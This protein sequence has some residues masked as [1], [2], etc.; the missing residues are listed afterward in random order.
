MQIGNYTV[1]LDQEIGRGGFGNVFRATKSERQ[2]V[3]AKR[4]NLRMHERAH[5]Q[6]AI[7]FYNRP[8]EHMNLIQL[9]D[10]NRNRDEGRDI[11]EFWV[12]MQYAE[13]GDLNQYFR[14]YFPLVQNIKQKLILMKQIARGIAYLH[15]QDIVH[16]DIKPA[17]I[18]VSGSHIPV[19][20]VIK[21]T[22]LGLAKF[23]DRNATSSGMS[24]IAG[25]EKFRAPEFWK[26]G[27]DG[28]I[29]YHRH[30]DTFSAGLTFLSMLQATEGTQLIPALESTL[31]PANDGRMPIG[32]EMVSRE[33]ANQ[34]SITLAAEEHH[35][36]SL[37]RGVK[38][39]I[40]NMLHMTPEDRILM[41]EVDTLFADE[42]NLIRKVFLLVS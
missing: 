9:F 18:L 6:E 31:D 35:D 32:L 25:T 5:I 16:R 26:K 1:H 15:S 34:P 8:P 24:S 21:I 12:F 7:S 41:E 10:I 22:D 40:R 14:G 33:R 19:E 27:C 36:C 38:F 3:A 20:A 4:I 17:N 13:H 11:D 2:V 23:L 39:V 42:E 29:R 37:T 28:R 30:V